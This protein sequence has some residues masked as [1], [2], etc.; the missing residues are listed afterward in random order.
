MRM[1]ALIVP[2]VFL[3]VM[4]AAAP[5]HAQVYR[6]V[7]ERG[8]I[9]YSNQL[10]VNPETASK[11]AIVEDR[12]SVYTPDAALL[13]AIEAD[14]RG[15]GPTRR[16]AELEGQ[17]DAERRARQYAAVAAAPRPSDP[18]SIRA[19]DCFGLSE[20]YYTRTIVAV[21]PR[22]PPRRFPHVLPETARM[23]TPPGLSAARPL[24]TVARP[25]P[26]RPSRPGLWDAPR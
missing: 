25:N 5:A 15:S 11:L 19:A 13:R 16:I 4:L 14:R 8:A 7:D 17:L 12:V 1:R 10:P 3:P 23:V 26:S 2:L 24:L 21:P 22:F 20:P 6:W 18:C 9:N